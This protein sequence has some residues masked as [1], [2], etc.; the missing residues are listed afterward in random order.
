MGATPSELA[1]YRD[2]GPIITEDRL[3][4]ILKFVEGNDTILIHNI[5]YG[6]ISKS[7][8]RNETEATANL[9]AV[10]VKFEVN[11]N[12]KKYDWVVKST[13]R[14]TEGWVKSRIRFRDDEREIKFYRD[15]LPKLKAFA[16]NK[17]RSHLVPSFC[18][19]PFASWTT[20]DKI[21]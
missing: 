17:N 20:N 9:F 15:L 18:S 10:E 8:R 7:A 5:E 6:I 1:Q 14:Y 3:Y 4:R 2:E 16:N 11:G 13:P 19:V 12:C 21:Q